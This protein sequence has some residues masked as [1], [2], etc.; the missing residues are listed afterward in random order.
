M[1]W[2]KFIGAG[3]VFFGCVWMGQEKTAGLRRRIQIL[4]EIVHGFVLFQNLTSTYRLPL[5]VVFKKIQMQVTP[6]VSEF[7]GYLAEGFQ[8]QQAMDGR[9]IWEN[10]VQQMGYLLDKEDQMLLFHLGD[11]LGL[12]DVCMQTAAVSD[13]IEQIKERICRLEAERPQKEKLYRVLSLTVSGFLILL[14]I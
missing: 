13:C 2:L 11:F 7:Y 10:T 3:C 5:A 4:R 6:P 12:Q 8:K 14:F 1:W 9:K